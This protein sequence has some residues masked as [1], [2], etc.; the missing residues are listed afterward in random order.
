MFSMLGNLGKSFL[1]AGGGN[2]LGSLFGG[3]GGGGSSYGGGS[4]GGGLGSFLGGLGK[5]FAPLMGTAGTALGTMFG[6]PAGGMLGGTLGNMASS[7]FG[8]NDQQGQQQQGQQQYGPQQSFGNQMGTQFGNAMNQG[9]NRYMPQ[10]LQGQTFGNMGGAVGNYLG[11][12]FGHPNAGQAIGNMLNPYIQQ[13]MPQ[14][15]RDQQMGNLGGYMGQQMGQRFDQGIQSRGFNPSMGGGYN[16]YQQQQQSYGQPPSYEQSQSYGQ[17]PSFGDGQEDYGVPQAPEAP[18]LGDL[19]NY[20]PGQMQG[21]RYNAPPAPQFNQGGGGYG[22]GNQFPPQSDARSNMLSQIRARGQQQP[23]ANV[24]YGGGYGG[25]PQAPEAPPLGDLANY[26]PGSAPVMGGQGQGGGGN[27][28]RMASSMHPASNRG[29]M[30]DE[31]RSRGG[32]GRMG[33]RPAQTRESSAYPRSGNDDLMA[34]MMAQRRG[35]IEPGRPQGNL[36]SGR[37]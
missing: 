24:G 25:A 20:N 31:L 33:L 1:G 19:A 35:A 18:P 10:Q 30:F 8:G 37:Y 6:G 3:G 17:Q 4:S 26:N 14:G 32:Q 12:K 21:Q 11:S 2:M 7:M 22:G 27:R 9:I 34:R 29:N 13:A 15:M 23:R 16:P 28:F 36:S 5:T